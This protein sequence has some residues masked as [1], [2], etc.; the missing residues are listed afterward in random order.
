MLS[1]RLDQ[2]K[3]L[4]QGIGTAL[5]GRLLQYLQCQRCQKPVRV[6]ALF[7]VRLGPYKAL[8]IEPTGLAVEVLGTALV[9]YSSKYMG[10]GGGR[11]GYGKGCY[12]EP[13]RG[14]QGELLR[15]LWKSMGQLAGDLPKAIAGSRFDLRKLP[16]VSE[17]VD[18]CSSAKLL[19]VEQGFLSRPVDYLVER[20]DSRNEQFEAFRR[21]Q[22]QAPQKLLELI[23]I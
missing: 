4:L 12:F 8:A 10:H 11:R 16:Q 14:S 5:E 13:Y 1:Y 20:W 3:V 15:D 2:Q 19:L 21:R 6:A 9:A 7:Q 18:H 17:A 22:E 23:A